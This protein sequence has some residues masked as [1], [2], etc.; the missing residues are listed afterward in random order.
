VDACR[1]VSVGKQQ[2]RLDGPQ[3]HLQQLS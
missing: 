1:R 2:F 3:A